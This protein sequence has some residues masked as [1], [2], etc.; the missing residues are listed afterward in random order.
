MPGG[1]AKQWNPVPER[2]RAAL[3]QWIRHRG[4]W[5][6]PLINACPKGPPSRRRIGVLAIIRGVKRLGVRAGLKRDLQPQMLR[7]AAIKQA[8]DAGWN[9]GEVRAFIRQD[10]LDR[11][12][13]T[14]RATEALIPVLPAKSVQRKRGPK[15]KPAP[16]QVIEWSGLVVLG[17][18]AD[19]IFVLGVEL[20]ATL[21][22]KQF[23]VL[24]AL[25]DAGPGGLTLAGLE[26]VCGGARAVLRGLKESHPGLRA[27][28]KTP[29][30]RNGGN[31]RI[32]FPNAGPT[33]P[34]VWK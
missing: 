19:P 5:P 8:L 13:P 2:T 9:A 10:R 23:K 32:G 27:V 20:Q 3:G 4:D 24:K 15:P 11:L 34:L 33:N 16:E 25:R 26:C 7:N 29:G 30:K 6:G 17:G 21:T 28:L 31:Y 18:T 1:S 14:V 22:R 12:Q